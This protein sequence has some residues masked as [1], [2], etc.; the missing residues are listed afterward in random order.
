M[1]RV[2]TVFGVDPLRYCPPHPSTARLRS[3]P[4]E[5]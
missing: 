2:I 3:T 4:H 1:Y 5:I